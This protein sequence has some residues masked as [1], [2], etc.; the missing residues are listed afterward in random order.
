MYSNL[1]ESA[2]PANFI[3]LID[4][5]VMNVSLYKPIV[6]GYHRNRV[7]TVS[8]KESLYIGNMSKVIA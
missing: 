8:L 5:Q 6:Y 4:W 3:H 1:L 7:M 2:K